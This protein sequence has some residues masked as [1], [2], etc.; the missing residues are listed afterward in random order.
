MIVCV[1]D[2]TSNLNN[3]NGPDMAREADPSGKRTLG[4]VTTPDRAVASDV[5]AL[6]QLWACLQ[7][8]QT[9]LNSSTLLA[10]LPMAMLIASV[11]HC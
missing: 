8:K 10:S 2:M 11:K 3:Q 5:T 1:L 4:V 9:L 7:L 6:D